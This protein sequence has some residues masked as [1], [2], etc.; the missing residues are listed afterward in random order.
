MPEFVGRLRTP[1]LATAPATPVVGE[2]YYDT[3]GNILYWWNGSAWVPA[4]AGA[5]APVSWT[6]APTLQAGVTNF[7]APYAVAAY[8]KSGDVVQLRGVLA[9]TGSVMMTAFT[10]PAGNRPLATEVFNW[11]VTHVN[12][13][14]AGVVS[15]N[16]G[17]AG[18][19]SLSGISFS[20]L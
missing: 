6:A 5:V 8:R 2:M 20:T 16:P 10:L 12:I 1:R 15:I 11:N 9:A 14:L 4:Q 17:G 18:W 3:V 13:D 7:G 19:V